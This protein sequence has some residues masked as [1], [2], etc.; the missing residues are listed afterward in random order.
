MDK[1]HFRAIAKDLHE[2][3]VDEQDNDSVADEIVL[4]VANA[5]CTTFLQLNSRFERSTFLNAVKNG[6]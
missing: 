6:L 5:L 3:I 2:I 4:K 1:K